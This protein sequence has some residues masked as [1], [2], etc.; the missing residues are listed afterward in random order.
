MA[1]EII[2]NIYMR[3]EALP[4]IGRKQGFCMYEVLLPFVLQVFASQ[5]LC[6]ND[7]SVISGAASFVID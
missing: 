4:C 2:W 1:K 3:K 6:K 5:S 7:S